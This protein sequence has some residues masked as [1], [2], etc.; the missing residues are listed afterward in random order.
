MEKSVM[1]GSCGLACML[2]RSKMSGEC[3]GCSSLKS[4]NCDIKACC[5]S[6]N[7]EGC[8]ECDKFPCDKEMFK[9]NKVCAFV[10]IAKELGVGGLSSL[11]LK[12][13]EKGITYHP[14]DGGKG[15]YDLLKTKEEVR[16]LVMQIKIIKEE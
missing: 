14:S 11:L 7:I 4:D 6:N 13:K 8:Y 10:E 3:Q 1:I 9:N 15:D 16:R 12:N 2:C 5:I